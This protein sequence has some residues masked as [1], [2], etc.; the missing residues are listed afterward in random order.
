MLTKMRKFF[1]ED[2]NSFLLYIFL[3]PVLCGAFGLGLDMALGQYTRSGIQNA[4]D[5]ATTAGANKTT[6]EGNRRVINKAQAESTI[7]SLYA[8]KRLAYPNVTGS[9][10]NVT[11]TIRSGRAGSPPMLETTIIEKSPTLFLHLVGVTELTYQIKSQARLGY[12]TE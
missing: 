3:M 9:P 10:S 8:D 6:Y 7:R 4:A 5:L 11:V 2:G 12:V 1:T